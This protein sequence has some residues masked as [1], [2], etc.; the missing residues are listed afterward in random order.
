[1]TTNSLAFRAAFSFTVVAAALGSFDARAQ[2]SG[3]AAAAQGLFDDARALMDAGKAAEAC[4]KFEESQK[5]DPASGTLVNLA[6]CYEDTGHI[7]SAWST[8]LEAAA[9]ASAAG[10]ADRERGARERAAA[11]APRVSKLIIDVPVEARI[12]GLTITRDGVA[13]GAP[14]WGD[15]VPADAGDHAVRAAAPGHQDWKTLAVVSGEGAT[16]HI[17]VPKLVA[18]A[19]PARGAEKT[20]GLGAQRVA[21]IAA[22]GIGVVGIAVGTVFGVKAISDKSDAD[23]SCNGTAC[24]TKQGVS[25]G[26]DAHSA[27]NVA[28]VGIIVGAVGVAAGAALW[29]TAPKE[30]AVQVGA[31]PGNVQIRGVF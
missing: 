18:N 7:A 3:N 10:N 12:D 27:G 4:P 13:V 14:Q 20:S 23:K 8:Y 31:G 15:A 17:S 9:S 2:E 29:F 16:V 24:T 30:N 1:M 28:T 6:K 5:L 19:A 21:A 26:N 22:G 11:L 25:A